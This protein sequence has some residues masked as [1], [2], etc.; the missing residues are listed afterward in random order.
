MAGLLVPEDKCLMH[1]ETTESAPL[2]SLFDVL[3]RLVVEGRIVFGPDG[4]RMS[5][6]TVAKV[7][8]ISLFL[9]AHRIDKYRFKGTEPIT[10]NVSFK[11][12]FQKLKSG[13][14]NDSVIF[15][16]TDTC[17]GKS[18]L[19]LHL[20]DQN[21]SYAFSWEL[22]QL[23]L[24]EEPVAVPP[25]T[26][27]LMITMDSTVFQRIIRAHNH[28][29]QLCQIAASA[30]PPRLYFVT[31][32]IDATLLNVVNYTTA[33]PVSAAAPAAEPKPKKRKRESSSEEEE[34]SESES[35][36]SS[37]EESGG[38][39][40]SGSKSGSESKKET[41]AVRASDDIEWVDITAK[42][43]DCDKRDLFSTN[44]LMHISQSVNCSRTVDLFLLKEY[45][46]ALR[47]HVGSLGLLVVVVA[48]STETSP[49]SLADIQ[50][51]EIA[52]HPLLLA[53]PD[54]EVASHIQRAP[55]PTRQDPS[56]PKRGG[57]KRKE[58]PAKEENDDEHS[59]PAE[60][61]QADDGDEQHEEPA[62]DE[63]LY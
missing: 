2:R 32:G 23:T 17:R 45:P 55:V 20:R 52:N 47:Y 35:E 18:T 50:Q 19:L 31:R 4:V 41:G 44:Q 63:L 38:G 29:G 9:P 25:L 11:Q 42:H 43:E 24:F 10:C 5:L 22:G 51:G 48:P 53:E 33:P 14:Q 57:R 46:I 27:S 21:N 49:V 58:A 60:E 39:S 12:I 40:K 7:I 34:A 6:Y 37:E 30:E 62:E 36:S 59:P 13:T 8:Y 26:F 28:Q 61:E 3:T 1:F 56:A 16:Y 15:Q 54:A